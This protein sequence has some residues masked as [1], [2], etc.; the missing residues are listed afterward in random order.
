MA[1]DTIDKIL[2]KLPGG[3][4]NGEAEAIR[5]MTVRMP[6]RLHTALREEAHNRNTSANRLAVAKLSITSEAL[7]KLVQLQVELDAEEAE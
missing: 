1:Q 7:D 3:G 4:N 2:Y 6:V 5:V